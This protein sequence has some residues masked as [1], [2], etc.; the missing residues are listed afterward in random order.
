MLVLSI[1]VYLN[2]IFNW[3]S[4]FGLV[5]FFYFLNLAN[6]EDVLQGNSRWLGKHGVPSCRPE[7]SEKSRLDLAGQAKLHPT[8][9]I[10]SKGQPMK[11]FKQGS[12]MLRFQV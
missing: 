8:F 4:W 7:C 3:T 12:D 9:T 11:G 1:D 2:F 10:K 6:L 5:L